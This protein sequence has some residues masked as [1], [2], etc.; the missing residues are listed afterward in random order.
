MKK[1]NYTP[2]VWHDRTPLEEGSI[3]YANSMNNIEKGITQLTRSVN[4]LIDKGTLQGETGPEGPRGEKGAKGDTGE[5]GPRGE[6]GEQGERGPQGPRGDRGERGEQGPQGIKG[7][8]GQDG[9]DGPEGPRGDRGEIGPRGPKGDKGEPGIQ[10]PRGETGMQ[11]ERGETGPQG[12]RGEKGPKGEPGIQGPRGETGMQ[13]D[14]GEPGIQ[15]ERGERGPKG[16]KGDKGD[17]G[18]Q[19]P[20]GIKGD[21]PDMGDYVSKLNMVSEHVERLSN[22][23]LDKNGIVTMI[24]IGQDVK[25]AMTGG[26]VPVVGENA[27][28]TI[29]VI[30]NSITSTKRTIIGNSA[31]ISCLS[32]PIKISINVLE[33]Q[34]EITIPDSVYITCGKDSGRAILKGTYTTNVGFP[35]CFVYFN[36]EEST[37]KMILGKSPNEEDVLIGIIL[38]NGNIVFNCNNYEIKHI[39]DKVDFTVQVEYNNANYTDNGCLWLPK[40]YKLTGEK[41][42]LVIF[43]HGSGEYINPDVRGLP[44]P[45]QYLLKMG[46][47]VLGMNGIPVQISGDGSGR[48]FNAP[49]ALDSYTKGYHYVINNFN[50]HR[51]VFITGMSLG[52]LMANQLVQS[53]TIPVIATGLLCPVIDYFKQ[54]W[55]RP[56]QTDQRKL[57]AK[58]FLMNNYDSFNFTPSGNPTSEEIQYFI[59][60]VDKTIGYNPMLKNEMYWDDTYYQYPHNNENNEYLKLKK[61]YPVPIKIWHNLDDGTVLPVYS[62]YF[63]KSIKKAGGIAEL[64]N[65]NNGG[66]NAW[67]NGDDRHLT[68][69]DGNE[70]TLKESGYELIKWFERF[71]K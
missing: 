65:F 50:I 68:D 25:E 48:H 69:I 30:D 62:E 45:F 18:P 52:G 11:G 56:W 13:G 4:E 47:A 5:Q 15:G 53:G 14:K 66:H 1:V 51:D 37:I 33:T 26:S 59:D 61:T 29:N 3:I 60:N 38:Y 9:A 58:Y 35:G 55:C 70:F 32:E 36:T 43:C 27:V 34:I 7:E 46:Y 6:K 67:D 8:A 63:I 16:D 24:N 17:P 20:K 64:K 2:N 54:A 40:N 19:G 28:N 57:I 41:T 21:T 23:K 31:L 22:S 12:P 71:D 10:G 44:N 39:T 49:F 42:R